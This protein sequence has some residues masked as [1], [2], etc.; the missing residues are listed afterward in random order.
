M[1]KA[2][3]AKEVVPVAN[4][5]GQ[6]GAVAPSFLGAAAS[7]DAGKGVSTDQADNLIPLI[8]VLQ[9]LS[10]VCNKRDPSYIEGAEPG[11]LWLKNSANPIV[12]GETGFV[13]QPCFFSKDWVE[14]V[15]RDAGGGYAG[16]HATLPKEAKELRDPK[17]PQ[18]VKYVMPNGNECIE[19]R[20]HAG[21]VLTDN[22]PLPYVIPMS[23]TAHTAS[24]GWMFMMNGKRLGGNKLPSWACT[25]RLKTKQK[26]NAAGTW[27]T[28][29]IIDEGY[30]PDQETYD[31]GKALFDAFNSGAKTYAEEDAVVGGNAVD[32]EEAM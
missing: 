23:S 30:V 19:T 8:Y 18:K 21:Y 9:P 24:R 17:N 14:W 2:A 29:D 26:S 10:P 31:A 32:S 22:G 13:F 16:R 5:A 25:Y 20:Y 28:W 6:S 12:D 4:G 7:A 3:K 1:A 11:A 27:F 15:P